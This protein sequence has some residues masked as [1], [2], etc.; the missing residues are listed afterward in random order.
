MHGNTILKKKKFHLTFLQPPA[1]YITHVTVGITVR[2]SE[3]MYV[4]SSA[5]QIPFFLVC[6]AQYNAKIITNAKTSVLKIYWCSC[7]SYNGR[8]N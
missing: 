1:L 3:V 8:N 5:K 7:H 6:S 2:H 4:N